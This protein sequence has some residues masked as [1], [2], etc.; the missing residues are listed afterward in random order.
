MAFSL[1]PQAV[2]TGLGRRRM[3]LL[4]LAGGQLGQGNGWGRSGAGHNWRS[5]TGAGFGALGS[6]VTKL[7]CFVIAAIWL[8]GP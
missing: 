7:S 5:A 6:S 1:L 2:A 8:A 3:E 4:P